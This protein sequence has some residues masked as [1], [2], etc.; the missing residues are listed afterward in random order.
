MRPWQPALAQLVPATQTVVMYKPQRWAEYGLDYYRLNHVQTVF[1]QEE[2]VQTA[3]SQGR[4]LCISEDKTLEELSH[5]PA[6]D[7]E[8]VHAIGG[9]TAFWA[10]PVK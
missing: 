2:F 9:Q 7:L 8:V 4:I 1:S 3:L 6:I 10:W 5:V